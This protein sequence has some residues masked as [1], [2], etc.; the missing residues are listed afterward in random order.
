[1]ACINIFFHAVL[2]MQNAGVLFACFI[3]GISYKVSFWV[4]QSSGYS[5]Q[6]LFY[7]TANL[8]K[9]K[10]LSGLSVSIG[11]TNVFFYITIF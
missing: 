11:N 5:S 7:F 3:L 4:H 8:L 2:T 10:P 6:F 1:M 9:I